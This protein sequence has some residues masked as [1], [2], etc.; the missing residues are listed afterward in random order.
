MTT[1][2]EHGK[3]PLTA[4][5]DELRKRIVYS[6]IIVLSFAAIAY[7]FKEPLLSLVMKPY[8][9]ALN[10]P[11]SLSEL[12]DFEAHLLRALSM[13]NCGDEPCF[14]DAER[15][16][17]ARAMR[18]LIQMSTG[19]IFTQPIEAF[20]TFLK[21]ALYMG[22][23]AGMPFVLFQ[24]WK[25]V[26]PALYKTERSFF[27]SFLSMGSLLFYAGAAFSYLFIIPIG[28]QFLVGVGQGVL[29]PLFAVGSYI[30][31]VMLMMLVFGLSFE[32]PLLMFLVVKMGLVK[33][34]TLIKNW[35][36]VIAGS[37]IVGG[38][39]TPPDPVSQFLLAG[40]FIVL[41]VIGLLVTLL[42]ERKVT[43]EPAEVV[44]KE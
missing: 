25:F 39:L 40:A 8:Q 9:Q 21:F 33:R 36:Y 16:T 5:L 41:Y 43:V 10:L 44:V 20:W 22:L 17:M 23:L 14:S 42:A 1:V 27:F 28:L 15:Q 3:M 13:A 6:L 34:Q 29:T 18:M 30:S 2:T 24:L 12:G 26:V 31:F 7:I 4:H 19:L 32:L 11:T 37:F 38:V 35:R